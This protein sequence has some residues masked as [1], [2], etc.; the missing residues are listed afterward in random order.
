MPTDTYPEKLNPAR[1]ADG[2]ATRE[3]FALLID[4]V[5]AAHVEANRMLA[6]CA[7]LGEALR[8]A[9][10]DNGP[11]RT[12]TAMRVPPCVTAKLPPVR[13]ASDCAALAIRHLNLFRLG[14]DQ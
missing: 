11:A 2:A 1:T 14:G 5:P 7:L 10:D 12:V 3:P 13:D 4:G 8:L 6:A 9:A